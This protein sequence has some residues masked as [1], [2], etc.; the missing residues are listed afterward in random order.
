M[1]KA[2]VT[3]VL[4]VSMGVAAGVKAEETSPTA[5]RLTGLQS[6]SEPAA[7]PGSLFRMMGGLL[8]CLGVF[9]GGVHLY[10]RFVAPVSQSGKRRMRVIERLP[11][12]QKSTL[13]MV[14][15]DGREILLT[16]GSETARV[17]QGQIPSSYNRELFEES[18]ADMYALKSEER[19]CVA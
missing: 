15:C 7:R 19:K 5:D 11:L 4:A 17:V 13:V 6:V 2:I 1:K 16:V 10:R 3:I 8:F 14:S 12:T 9:G 18:I